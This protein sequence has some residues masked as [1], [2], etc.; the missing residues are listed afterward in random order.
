MAAAW[1]WVAGFSGEDAA[2][3]MRSDLTRSEAIRSIPAPEGE[4]R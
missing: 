2:D 1:A 4:M 3:Q